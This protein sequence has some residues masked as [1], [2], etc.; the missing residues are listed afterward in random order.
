MATIGLPKGEFLPQDISNLSV[1]PDNTRFFY[2]TEN[3][4]GVTGTVGIFGQTNRIVF[5][6]SPFTEW[7][8]QWDAKN[9]V[10]LTTKPSYSAT[11]SIFLLNAVNKTITKVLGGINGLTTLISP[12]GS[13]VLFSTSTDT[14]P[15]LGVYN[16]NKHTTFD[17]DKYGLPEKCV[18][19]S[20]NI[21]I[22]CAIP[23]VVTGN[24]YPDSWYQG[25]VS[26]DD[27][28]VK[29]NTITGDTE[30]LANSKDETPIDG[31]NLFLNRD[32]NTVFFTNKKDLTLWGMNI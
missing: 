2:I 23:N 8:S 22:Y 17:L 20:D 11:G 30:T 15:K 31:I 7:L 1:S 27:Y 5:F 19:S 21:N 26:F 4:S 25:L 9:N 13:Y 10:Y 14:G 32:E 28:F 6:N 12:N 29:I 18:W 3:N 16:I 24:Q